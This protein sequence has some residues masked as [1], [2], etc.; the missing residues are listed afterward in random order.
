MNLLTIDLE[1]CNHDNICVSECPSKLI[2]LKNNVPQSIEGA[3]MRCVKC[4]HCVVVCPTGALSVSGIE[5]EERLPIKNEL[6]VSIDQVEQLIKTRRSIRNY[7]NKKVE[8]E[9]LKKIIEIAR[10]APTGG[11]SQLVQWR[12]IDS[13]D[14]LDKLVDGTIEFMKYLIKENH[15]MASSYNLQSLVNAWEHKIDGI[16]RGAPALIVSHAPQ[17]YGLGMVDGSVALGYLDIA[18]S[19]YGLGCCWAGF[20]MMAASHS[21]IIKDVLKLPEG[22]V[23]LGALMV[24]Y[25]KFKYHRVPPRKEAVIYW[26]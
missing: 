15:P 25:P 8:R 16:L 14:E 7:Q 17:S 9:K 23:C 18:A 19:A 3:E 4:G 10:Y 5:T 13:R 12:A 22:N 1:K 26:S 2:T 11:N 24:G 6:K 21:P 20:F